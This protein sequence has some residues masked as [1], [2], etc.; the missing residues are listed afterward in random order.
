MAEIKGHKNIEMRNWDISL[1]QDFIE[2]NNETELQNISGIL[3][4][5]RF[6]EELMTNMEY[7]YHRGNRY[8]FRN[9][10]GKFILTIN[11]KQDFKFKDKYTIGSNNGIQ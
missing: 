8:F 7:Y 2:P 9:C 10:L 1:P 4:N 3:T 5:D 11:N 6:S